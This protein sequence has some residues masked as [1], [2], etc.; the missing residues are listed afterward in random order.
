MFMLMRFKKK[1]GQFIFSL[2]EEDE[3]AGSRRTTKTSPKAGRHLSCVNE[4]F[5]VTVGLLVGNIF[6]WIHF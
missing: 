5:R 6:D 2:R 3:V 1:M 4:I